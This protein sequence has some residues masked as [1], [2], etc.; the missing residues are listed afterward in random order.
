MILVTDLH[1]NRSNYLE[2]DKVLRQAM[3]LGRKT[4]KPVVS[5]GDTHDTKALMRGECVSAL[6]QTC[7]D[8]NDVQLYLLVGNHCLWN[9]KDDTRHSLEFLSLCPN[10]TI[11]SNNK[12]VSERVVGSVGFIPY[13]A[14]PSTIDK[15]LEYFRSIGVSILMMHQGVRTAFM[16]AGKV[17]DDGYDPSKLKGFQVFVGHYHTAHYVGENI[18][19]IGSSISHSFAEANE[20]KQLVVLEP[21]SGIFSRV[22]VEAP[23]HRSYFIQEEAEL[24]TPLAEQKEYDPVR[25]IVKGSKDFIDKM[26]RSGILKQ[27]G[28]SLKIVK[29]YVKN[30]EDIEINHKAG[31]DVVFQSFMDRQKLEPLRKAKVLENIKTILTSL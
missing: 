5:L 13:K 14:D 31:K 20:L 19:F 23:Q 27:Y 29:E 6:I 16:N 18:F 7:K 22:P 26:V 8:Y 9:V 28:K 10:V 12:P 1:Y 30:S 4:K 17:D 15:E 24:P 25:V 11:M 2:V 3:E 21:D